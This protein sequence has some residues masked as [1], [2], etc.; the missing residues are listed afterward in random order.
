MALVCVCVCVLFLLPY[1]GGFSVQH[2]VGAPIN[3]HSQR[4]RC[5]METMFAIRVA[6]HIHVISWDWKMVEERSVL[7][8]VVQY[9]YTINDIY[10]IK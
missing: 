2:F 5:G 7:C 9:K 10:H 1:H 4:S 6:Q 3:E 8:S